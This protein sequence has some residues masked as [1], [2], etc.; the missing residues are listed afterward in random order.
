[1]R[2]LLEHRPL[3][4]IELVADENG[5]GHCIAPVGPPHCQSRKAIH[6]AASGEMD[7][8]F[9]SLLAMTTGTIPACPTTMLRLTSN[10]ESR[11]RYRRG[12]LPGRRS[13]ARQHA[14]RADD[15]PRANRERA[16]AAGRD[17]AA[18][19]ELASC[20]ARSRRADRAGK[21]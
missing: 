9:P 1:P 13:R 19:R 11:S 10:Y 8:F 6:Y 17:H 4:R 7:C 2:I 21:T 3:E 18:D 15:R 12:R 14:D 20:Q 16:G 5:D